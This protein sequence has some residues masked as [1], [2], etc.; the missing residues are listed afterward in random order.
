VLLRLLTLPNSLPPALILA[1][2]VVVFWCISF[3]NS[4]KA[5]SAEEKRLFSRSVF[6]ATSA[7][8]AGHVL[9]TAA[10]GADRG[11]YWFGKYD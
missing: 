8:G 11:P 1:R 10:E 4:P 3:A 7:T 6:G 5:E 2:Q 9:E